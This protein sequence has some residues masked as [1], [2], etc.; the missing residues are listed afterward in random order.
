V[1][2]SSTAW[3]RFVCWRI[4]GGLMDG[5]RNPPR[6]NGRARIARGDRLR[7]RTACAT[8]TLDPNPALNNAH[9]HIVLAEG[10]RRAG[11]STPDAF[12]RM[13]VESAAPRS[14]NP[15]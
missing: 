3:A 8:G 6:Q 15:R 5:G 10:C 7:G 14:C 13:E 4:P 11:D 12:E 9:C 1:F 2:V